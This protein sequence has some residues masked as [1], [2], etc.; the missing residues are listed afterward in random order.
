M[1]LDVLKGEL[2]S[3]GHRVGSYLGSLVQAWPLGKQV[4]LWAGK[5]TP[6]RTL[7]FKAI[8]C[9]LREVL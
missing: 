2:V 7:H 9:A 8:G 3:T 4:E 5:W 6:G 1:L